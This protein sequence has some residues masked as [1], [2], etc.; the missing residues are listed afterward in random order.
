MVMALKAGHG[1]EAAEL[2]AGLSAI[3]SAEPQFLAEE[4]R[5]LV[6]AQVDR[7]RVRSAFKRSVEWKNDD[8]TVWMSWADYE[9]DAGA[10]TEELRLLA[11]CASRC[12]DDLALNCELAS[13]IADAFNS[14]K[15]TVA[16]DERVPYLRP[17]R[18]NLEVRAADLDAQGLSR[19]AWLYLLEG[20]EAR[21][22]TIVQMGLD[23][24]GGSKSRYLVNLAERLD[25]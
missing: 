3:A 13:R 16:A 4:A 12:P 9:R 22:R 19:L 8:P 25:M 7:E 24:P 6:L 15:F 14:V 5:F 2:L 20:D 11:S 10:R 18:E 21:A 23:R 17:C 1:D